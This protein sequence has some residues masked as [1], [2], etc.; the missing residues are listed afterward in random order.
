MGPALQQLVLLVLEV[1]LSATEEEA[2]VL[3]GLGGAT[4]VLDLLKQVLKSL[5]IEIGYLVEVICHEGQGLRRRRS[6]HLLEEGVSEEVLLPG[7][8]KKHVLGG[9]QIENPLVT[10]V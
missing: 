5:E 8:F 1:V 9:S 2:Q 3:L 4:P 6:R 7:L 10:L